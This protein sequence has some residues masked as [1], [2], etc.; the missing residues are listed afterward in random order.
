TFTSQVLD[1][2]AGWQPSVPVY[3]SQHNYK[4]VK[5]EDPAATSRAKQTIDMLG[6]KRWKGGADHLLWLTEGGYNLGSSWPDAAAR[7]AQAAKIDKS[8]QGMKTLPD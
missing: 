2:L 7:D 6:A 1:S 8:F 5:Y 3:W 4:D